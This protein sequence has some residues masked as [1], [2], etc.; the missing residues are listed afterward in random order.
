MN[1]AKGSL[2]SIEQKYKLFQQQQFTFIAALEHCREN[3]HDK[4]R[5]I[6]SI[7]QVPSGG[8]GAGGSGQDPGPGPRLNDGG[9]E[10]GTG[11]ARLCPSQGSNPRCQDR[12][13]FLSLTTSGSNCHNGVKH[14]GLRLSGP[15]LKSRP[16]P[17][18]LYDLGL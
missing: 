12:P 4:I 9:M 5:P 16:A 15:G 1:E 3:A 18:P 10:A 2:R 6:S 13:S 14:R 7:E 11:E 8:Q 17:G